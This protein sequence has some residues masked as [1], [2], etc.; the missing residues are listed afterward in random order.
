MPKPKV[1]AGGLVERTTP[2]G[3][4][5]AVVLRTRYGDWVLPKGKPDGS[6]TLE[7]TALREV[8]EETGC[9][10]RITGPGYTIEYLVGRVPKVVTF[11]RM[12]YVADG[13]TIDPREI[14][15]VVW[16]APRRALQRLTYETE[17]SVVRRVYEDK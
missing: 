16:L 8:R 10:A 4:Q 13:F 2:E 9:E 3:T 14:E 11:F 12:E 17:R 1:A 7:E 5:L 15:D 6:E